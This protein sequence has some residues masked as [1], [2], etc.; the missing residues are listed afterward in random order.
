MILQKSTLTLKQTCIGSPKIEVFAY[1]RLLRFRLLLHTLGSF[2]SVEGVA[3]FRSEIFFCS[4]YLCRF[5]NT[6]HKDAGSQKTIG[7]QKTLSLLTPSKIP[8]IDA[9]T[10]P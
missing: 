9:A 7:P 6:T 8:A 4:R 10:R 2:D 5:W 3:E 1:S